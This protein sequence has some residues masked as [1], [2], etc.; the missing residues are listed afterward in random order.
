MSRTTTTDAQLHHSSTHAAFAQTALDS[1]EYHGPPVVDSNDSH[2]IKGTPVGEHIYGRGGDDII[3]GNGGADTFHFQP[4]DGH[5]VIVDFDSNDKIDLTACGTF[6]LFSD[7]LAVTKVEGSG[8]V[9]ATEGGASIRLLN[10]DMSALR[11]DQFLLYGPEAATD[12]THSTLH[13]ADWHI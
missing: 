8:L 6:E 9:I 4:G 5:D 3:W 12:F 2:F 1:I 7:V 10:T 11:A 13:H